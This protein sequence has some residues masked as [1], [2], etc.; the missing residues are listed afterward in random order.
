MQYQF[1]TDN[2]GHKRGQIVDLDTN[3]YFTMYWLK[4]GIIKQLKPYLV[5]A[6]AKPE[7][8]TN[9]K[10]KKKPAKKGKK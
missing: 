2:N 7:T 10:P 5:K 3:N 8:K 1:L 6:D 4:K 9:T